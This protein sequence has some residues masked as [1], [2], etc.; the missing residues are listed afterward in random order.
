MKDPFKLKFHVTQNERIIS[1]FA[2]TITIYKLV[3]VSETTIGFT[4]FTIKRIFKYFLKKIN[5]W[6]ISCPK[7]TA[8]KIQIP[9]VTN[10]K[11]NKR[12][13]FQKGQ[14]FFVSFHLL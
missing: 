14:F 10:E 7:L 3:L 6:S 13:F 12:I 9:F 2:K 8:V 5:I 4:S 11:N 1:N